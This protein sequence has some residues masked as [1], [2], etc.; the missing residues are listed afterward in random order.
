M[1]KYLIKEINIIKPEVE[2][3][4]GCLVVS[5]EHRSAYEFMGGGPVMPERWRVVYLEPVEVT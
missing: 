4:E 2:L 1:K 3:P 5:V